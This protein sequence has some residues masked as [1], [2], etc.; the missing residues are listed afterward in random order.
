MDIEPLEVYARD[1]NY[2]VVKPPGRN[3]PGAVIQGDSLG[4]LARMANNIARAVAENRASGEDF[5][6][7]VQELNN[8][9]VGRALHYQSVLDAHEIAYPI[10]PAITEDQ[11]VEFFP[12][13]D[14]D[15]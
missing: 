2:A 9:L 4:I 11:I 13:D 8:L 12:D 1:S 5:L 3:Y 10:H 14:D 6:G 15:D 7:N